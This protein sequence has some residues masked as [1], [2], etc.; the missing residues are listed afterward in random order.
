VAKDRY[1]C[2]VVSMKDSVFLGSDLAKDVAGDASAATGMLV[3]ETDTVIEAR[4]LSTIFAV[5]ET[6]HE[7]ETLREDDFSVPAHVV[8]FGAIRGLDSQSKHIDVVSVSAELEKLGTF[9][10]A[11]GSNAV[12]LISETGIVLA[13]LGTYLSILQERALRRRVLRAAG[14]IAALGRELN[15]DSYDLA[16]EAQSVIFAATS[17]EEGEHIVKMNEL[18][19]RMQALVT[20]GNQKLLGTPTGIAELDTETGGFSAGQLVIIGARPGVGKSVMLLQMAIQAAVSTG[21]PVVFYSYEMTAEEIGF[22]MLANLSGVSM[23]SLMR[24]Q[25]SREQEIALTK[26]VSQMSLLPLVIDDNPPKGVNG[27]RSSARKLARVDGLGAIFVD[28]LQLMRS[29][30]NRVENRNQEVSEMSRGLKLLSKEVGAPVIAASQ[31]N[32]AIEARG[33]MHRKPQLSDLRDSGS[34][35]QDANI[36]LFLNRESTYNPEAAA[37]EGELIVAKNRQGR[38]NFTIGLDWDGDK[39]RFTQ[40]RR[41]VNDPHGF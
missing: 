18:A 25:L 16:D 31:L 41:F 21:K 29:E 32:R 12:T 7:L 8:I 33:G 27:I 28:Y 17:T 2:T 14:H 13:E 6:L 39:M 19:I 11:G 36:V 40:S 20:G 15:V 37:D 24:G 26:G 9:K 34:V 30:S 23:G 22:R 3:S 10:L 35:E 4:I 38:S 1:G 5:P